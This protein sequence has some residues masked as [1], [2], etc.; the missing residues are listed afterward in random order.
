M[1]QITCKYTAAFGDYSGYGEAGRN[2]I[3]ALHASG[4]GLT[5][6]YV[7]NVADQANYGESYEIAKEA[8]GRDIPYNVKIIHTTP[9]CYIKYLEPLKYHIGHL[10]WET[11]KLPP[12]WVWNANLM[13]EIWTGSEFTKNAFIQSGVTCPIFVYPQAIETH[14]PPLKPFHV[15]HHQGYLFYSIFQWIERKNPKALLTAYWQEFQ[16]ED[17]VTLLLKV[18]RMDFGRDEKS[19][20]LQDID[21]WKRE[22]PQKHFPRVVVTFELMNRDDV[23]RVHATGDCFVSAHRGE[24]WGVPQVEAMSMAKPVISTSLG[25][26]HEWMKHGETAF[27]VGWNKEPVHD[28]DFV[29][30]YGKDQ[31]WAS[32][33]ILDLRAKMRYVF[34]NPGKAVQV[35]QAAQQMVNK[36][37]SYAIVGEQMRLRLEEI[38]RTIIKK[39]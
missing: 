37:F 29:P 35:G 23:Y 12:L 11:D 6:E 7:S 32:V 10:F 3:R 9:D 34:M 27:L 19:K 31:N 8:E 5:T 30:W 26:C 33:D 21:N 24:G 15:P 20:I 22:M 2:A 13:Q 39:L 16:G 14:I 28:M 18:Y 38:E 36:T 25:G 17:N 4:V 1:Q